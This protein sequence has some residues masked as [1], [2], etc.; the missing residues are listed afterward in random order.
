MQKIGNSNAKAK[1]S[2]LEERVTRGGKCK[3]GHVW[4]CE[5]VTSEDDVDE[6]LNS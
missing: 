6:N 1:E 2:S 3:K 4:A 5:N